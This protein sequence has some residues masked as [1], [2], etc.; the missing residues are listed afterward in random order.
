MV[1]SDRYADDVV[2]ELPEQEA[3]TQVGPDAECTALLDAGGQVERIEPGPRFSPDAA[4][5]WYVEVPQPSSDPPAS[6]LVAFH[7][8]DVPGGT[9][10]PPGASRPAAVQSSDQVAA[11]RWIPQTGQAHEIYVQPAWRGRG[12]ATGLGVVC[13][14]VQTARGG[15]RI[16]GDGSRTAMGE[17]WTRGKD[18]AHLVA[19]LDYLE[20]P[21]TP[22]DQR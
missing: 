2:V 6:Y 8:H 9:V 21:M 16:W 5:L 18:W 13:A 15:P 12:I 14:T 11:V 20:A 4:H 19:E 10:V 17:K 7:G 22:F 1:R 3:R